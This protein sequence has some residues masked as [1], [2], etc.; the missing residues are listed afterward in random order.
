MDV[1]GERFSDGTV[2]IPEVLLSARALNAGMGV[3]EPF[4]HKNKAGQAESPLVV[5]GTVK[6]DLHDIGKNLVGIMFR[7]VGLRVNDLG[8]NVDVKKIIEA[9]QTHQPKILALSALLTTTMS[10]FAKIIDALTEAGL[11]DGVKII[12]GGAPVSSH[13][14]KSIG[15]DGYGADAGEAAKIAKQ[16]CGM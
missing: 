16:L 9:V 12:V 14:A 8:I 5:L 11:R 15:A 10:E 7:S 6:G 13:F 4:L 3:I 1:I 2:F